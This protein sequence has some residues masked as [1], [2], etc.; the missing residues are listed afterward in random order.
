[1]VVNCVLFK[2]KTINFDLITYFFYKFSKKE[3]D[4]KSRKIII[5]FEKAKNGRNIYM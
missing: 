5:V 2:K 1:M 3:E 4:V